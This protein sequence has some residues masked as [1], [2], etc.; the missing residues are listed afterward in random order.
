MKKKIVLITGNLGYIG[1]E[2]SKYLKKKDKNIFLI[3][4]DN[5]YF[6]KDTINKK[7]FSKKFIDYQQY[8]DIRDLKYKRLSCLKIDTVIYLAA[9][10]ND[11]MG[12]FF[13]KPTKQI[14]S[15]YTKKFIDWA[16]NIG[17][18]R[19]VFASSCSVYGFSKKICKENSKT[20]PLTEYAKSKVD[21]EN[22]LKKKTDKDFSAISL[23]FSTA[24]GASRMLRLDLVLNDF[25]ASA[26]STKEIKLLSNGNALRPLI[27]VFDMCKTL[28]WASKYK[29]KK[30]ICVNVGN[31][32]MN[33]KIVDLAYS[34]K[35]FLPKAKISI[36]HDNFD[37]RS[38]K[39][40]FS[41]L[42]R[43][44]KGYNTMKNLNYSIKN[45]IKILKN[46]DFENKN[47]RGS[48]FMRLISLK[49]Q[50]K[51]GKINNNLRILNDKRYYN[52]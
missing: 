49:N 12:N 50:I 1:V 13:I 44:Y 39:V 21:I 41:K 6:L 37:N 18:K 46:N 43:I 51:Q 45:L 2:L 16:K 9:I 17:V 47:F 8:S 25:V 52:Y 15:L 7:K 26:I 30:Y 31:D 23:R 22:Y 40:G 19:F 27:D 11:P 34:V 38:Y 3:G 33:F 48:K 32:K 4:C 42:K 35:K 20:K 24:C 10:S 5:G 29:F 36:N 14:N 28:I